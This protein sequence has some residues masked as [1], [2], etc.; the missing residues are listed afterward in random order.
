MS[1]LYETE[2]NYEGVITE[3]SIVLEANSVGVQ[4]FF[5]PNNI[6]AYNKVYNKAYELWRKDKKYQESYKE[7]EKAKK[8]LEKL[9]TKAQTVKD[10]KDRKQITKIIDSRIG[11]VDSSLKMVD[12]KIQKEMKKA[13]K[14]TTKESAFLEEKAMEFLK[15]NYSDMISDKDFVI[16]VQEIDN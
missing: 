4:N 11:I 15:E 6:A 5:S 9:M 16:S 13:N 1:I 2:V 7:F 14:K 3:S 12:K 10:E 8:E